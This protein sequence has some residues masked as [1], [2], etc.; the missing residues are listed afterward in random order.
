MTPGDRIEKRFWRACILALLISAAGMSADPEPRWKTLNHEARLAIEA[1]DYAK[2]RTVL[3]EL[4]PL[5]PGNPRI[6]YNLAASEARLGN[7]SAAIAGLRNLVR[8]GLIYDFRADDDFNSLRDSAD[9]ARILKQ[10]DENRKPVTH[11]TTAFPLAEAD[12]MPEDIAFDQ[13]TGRFF[14]S[15]VTTCRVLTVDGKEFA[16]T[17]WSAMALRIDP[18][19]RLLWVAT[20]WAPMGRGLTGSDKDKT[21]VLAFDLDSGALKQRVDSPLPGVLGDM[22]ISRNGDLYISEGLNGAILRLPS[23]ASTM[24]RLD[25]PGEFPSPQTPA[26]SPDERTL[27]IPDYLRGIAAMDVRTRKVEWLQPAPDI[28]LSGID[29]LYLHRGSCIA[30]QN[31]TT[32]PRIVRLSLDLKKQEILEANWEGLGEPTHGRFVGDDFYFTANVGFDSYDHDG[33]KKPGSAPVRSVVR[34]M[35]LR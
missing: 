13:K 6:A 9:F 30:V 32:P 19:R 7:P 28:A 17:P 29:G 20:A 14:V 18:A 12:L 16:R 1:K 22:T 21:A 23:D 25:A 3:L 4:K 24:E 5:L 35:T 15:S 10:V 2:L 26:L 31:G 27:Y 33:K 8:M 11:S 34:K